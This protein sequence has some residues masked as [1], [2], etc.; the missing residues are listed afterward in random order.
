[1][2]LIDYISKSTGLRKSYIERVVTKAPYSYKKYTIPKKNGGVREIFHPRAELKV[3][4]R[5]LVE[6]IISTF[7]VHNCVYSYRQGRGI[8]SHAEVHRTNNFILRVDL[9]NFFPSIKARDIKALCL[10][11][12]DRLPLILNEDDV[13]IFCRIVCIH[14]AIDN[15]LALT[16]GSPASPAIS[17]AILFEL[18]SNISEY[19]ER[20]NVSY[21]RYADDLYFS[22]NQPQVLEKVYGKVCGHLNEINSPKLAINEDKTVYTSKKRRRVVTGVVLTSDNKLSI[23]RDEKR[24][25]RTEIYIYLKG[26]LPV[27]KASTLRGQLNYYQ[28]IEPSFLISLMRKFG[29]EQIISFMKPVG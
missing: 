1:M 13:K 7:P 19:C 25:V 11:N 17:N 24:R 21:T 12:L 16:I 6:S 29:K 4:Q 18:D 20:Y 10:K 5:F 15:E 9:R 2:T 28:S 27:D 26:E 8:K 3:I 14:S 22:T 23:G